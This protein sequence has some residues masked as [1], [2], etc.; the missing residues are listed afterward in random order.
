[1]ITELPR[2]ISASQRLVEFGALKCNMY[3]GVSGLSLLIWRVFC[4]HWIDELLTDLRL[5]KKL[6]G[7]VAPKD[8]FSGHRAPNATNRVLE[9]LFTMKIRNRKEE[10]C[11][12]FPIWFSSGVSVRASC[13][14]GFL[15]RSESENC[16][17]QIS[18]PIV[19]CFRFWQSTL[20]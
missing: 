2:S 5:W 4:I 8:V 11:Q 14:L 17:S 13:Q 9:V 19:F 18:P 16:P 15:L 3:T 6:E 1:M 7:I 10:E 12:Q 20:M